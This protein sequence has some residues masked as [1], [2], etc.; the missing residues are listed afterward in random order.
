MAMWALLQAKPAPTYVC[1]L[2]I[3]KAFPSI[4]H[5]LLYHALNRLGVPDH[6]MRLIKNIYSNST[7][8]FQAPE[9][10][11][12]YTANRGM[13]EG[14]PLSPAFFML[15]YEALHKTLR[16]E[17]PLAH[18]LV[19]MDDIAILTSSL[20]ELQTILQRVTQLVT[21]LGFKVNASKTELYGWDPNPQPTTITWDGHILTCNKPLFRY[22]GHW[23]I[24]PA[25]RKEASSRLITQV[26]ADLS[27][28][29]SLPL[30]AW[31]KTQLTNSVLIPRWAYHWLLLAD[32]KTN[33]YIDKAIQQFV[34]SSKGMEKQRYTLRLHT[35]T[36]QGGM[37]LHQFYW[38][39]RTR[40]IAAVQHELRDPESPLRL[41]SRAPIPRHIHLL[42][43]YHNL[44]KQLGGNTPLKL[45]AMHSSRGSTELFDSEDSIAEQQLFDAQLIHMPSEEVAPRYV[46]RSV[47][48]CQDTEVQVNLQGMQEMMTD[49]GRAWVK[50]NSPIGSTW[51]TDGSKLTGPNGGD[52]AGA[53]ICNGPLEVLIRVSGPQT[54]Y[55][56]ETLG[57][58]IAALWAKKNDTIKLDNKGVVCGVHDT[59]TREMPDR[60]LRSHLNALVKEKQLTV[61]WIPSHQ[62]STD[63]HL[64]GEKESIQQNNRV[65]L[66]AKKAA[67]LPVQQY[68]PTELED[69]EIS[70]GPAPT[71]ARKWILL[72]RRFGT[73]SG[74]HWL[75]WLPLRGQRRMLWLQWLWGN[76]R[77]EGCAAPWCKERAP[78]SICGTTHSKTVHARLRQ[79]TKWWPTFRK[80]WLSSWATWYHPAKGWLQQATDTD[81]E[82]ISC[83]R[84]PTSLIE[85]I[86]TDLRSQLRER[87]AW[88][89]YHMLLNTTVLRGILQMPPRDVLGNENSMQPLV[90]PWFRKLQPKVVTPNPTPSRLHAQ[91]GLP[92]PWLR[93]KQ[94]HIALPPNFFHQRLKLLLQ[95]Q[96]S[97]HRRLQALSLLPLIPQGEEASQS[98]LYKMI[99]ERWGNQMKP[100]TWQT[101]QGC[102]PVKA[103]HER[104]LRI[105]AIAWNDLA[106]QL[107]NR[108]HH[109]KMAIFSDFT[110]ILHCHYT[111]TNWY[112]YTQLQY[113]AWGKML[114]RHALTIKD[115]WYITA[116]TQAKAAIK[117]AAWCAEFVQHRRIL[118]QKWESATQLLADSLTQQATRHWEI[119]KVRNRI[120]S[121]ESHSTAVEPDPHAMAPSEMAVLLTTLDDL[122]GEDIGQHLTEEQL[123]ADAEGQHIPV[124]EMLVPIQ[125]FP[126]PFRTH[127]NKRSRES[128]P[129]TPSTLQPDDAS[130]SDHHH[131]RRR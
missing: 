76:V 111:S 114:V 115:K 110:C 90:P 56:A 117:M 26:D 93:A 60:D 94:N 52:Q 82:H 25:H 78:C 42:H 101:T 15:V 18:F 61:Q 64:P 67:H 39:I 3:A 13:K 116:R 24:H 120:T 23:I 71:P 10:S 53:A 33:L 89:Q 98:A 97:M 50:D 119:Q 109:Q 99:R 118:T 131:R 74:T 100:Q 47:M 36:K 68:T 79:C 14:C 62:V 51:H 122:V 43:I 63:A 113:W 129:L 65:D 87:V 69:L 96:P 127:P 20:S 58:T 57:A 59:L 41:L 105:R 72:H 28:Y 6:I 19:Y 49:F 1:L 21:I 102:L 32:D 7:Y 11:F 77:W 107:Q 38:A 103:Q 84:V 9:G 73:W 27:R 30:N 124:D 22:L 29:Y 92:T 85:A 45:A 70:G 54:S 106:T 91:V 46:H 16:R 112:H 88:H 31:E 81:M 130:S 37:G 35:P 5:R 66:L 126:H 95:M 17:F 108:V 83:L 4:P 86:P 80:V 48:P 75:T 34:T 104:R 44:V 8:T 12:T 2:D 128:P 121:Q 55:R 125:V 40:W 123:E